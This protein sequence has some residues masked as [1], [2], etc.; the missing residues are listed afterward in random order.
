MTVI[1][2]SS[3]PGQL[4]S[5]LGE[6]DPSSVRGII[7]FGVA[8]GLDPMLATGDIVVATEV[9]IGGGRWA[10]AAGLSGE[11]IGAVGDGSRRIVRGILA[12]SEV[13]VPSQAEKARLRDETSADA[14][15]MESHIAAGYAEAVGLPFAALRVVSDPASRALPAIAT[16]ALKPDGRVD[17]WRVLRAIARQPS[18]VPD[19]IRTGRDFNH[20]IVTLRGC[21]RL[22]LGEGSRLLGGGG[23][24]VTADL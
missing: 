11:L 1:C 9:V 22:L 21:R 18:V 15:D 20:A 2:S 24:L 14:V 7:S 8:G 12:G 16:S 6:F 19:L 17:I 23:S 13:V 3:D 4:R 5:Q 10:A